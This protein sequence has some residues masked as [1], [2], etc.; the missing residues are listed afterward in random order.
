MENETNK[1]KTDTT[2]DMY[3]IIN[4]KFLYRNSIINNFIMNENIYFIVAGKGIGKSLLLIYKRK[5]LEKKYGN[6]VLL[7]PQDKPYIGFM[8]DMRDNMGSGLIGYLRDWE[9][10]KKIWTLSIQI[11]AL[12]QIGIRK[13]EFTSWSHIPSI[14]I[15]KQMM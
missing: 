9:K 1:W 7:L 5:Y 2:E 13:K 3:D 14:K 12:T 4:D 10:C 15:D 11:S 8:S 6:T